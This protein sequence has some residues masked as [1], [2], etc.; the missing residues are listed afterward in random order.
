MDE[1]EYRATYNALNERR[2]W[3]EKAINSRVCACEKAHRFNLADREGVACQSPSGHMRCAGLV[4]HLRAAAR[5]ALHLTRVDAPLPH[6]PEI[7]VQNGG[8]LGLQRALSSHEQDSNT[9]RDVFGLV[10]GG[11]EEYG[12]LQ[13]LPYEEI[14]KSIV[15]Y[16]SRPRR[17]K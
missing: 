9:V 6:S 1:K 13:G 15:N 8:L 5:F 2:C 11:L 4:Q 10:T 12:S 3:F 14:V 16:Q 17:K 7:K